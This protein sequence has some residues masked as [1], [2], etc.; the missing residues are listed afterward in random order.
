MNRLHMDILDPVYCRQWNDLLIAGDDYSVFHTANWAR[1][2]NQSYG[3]EPRY[4]GTI[5]SG[6]LT[7]LVPVM[8]INSYLTGRRGV[9]LPFSDFCEPIL[10]KGFGTGEMTKS[11][12]A[13]GSSVGWKFIEFRGDNG[14]E[15]DTPAYRYYYTHTVNLRSGEKFLYDGLRDS[16][17]RNILKSLRKKVTVKHGT[18]R[19]F[20]DEFYRMNCITRKKHG[21]PPQPYLFFEKLQENLLDQGMGTVFLA[22]YQG[23]T[24]AGSV[25]L[26]CGDKVLYKY[27]ASDLEY[28]HLR[29]NN[30]VMWEAIRFYSSAGYGQLSFGRTE[31]DNE[32]LRQFKNGWGGDEQLIRYYRYDIGGERYVSA[33]KSVTKG[34]E[35]LASK[36]PLPLLKIAGKC[37]YRHMG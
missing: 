1:T 32:G 7:T 11:I 3:Y 20:V 14:Q 10:P 24:I 23:A 2:L 26:N 31:P 8:E 22:D 37:L 6:R 21:L 4:F 33:E 28:L 34:Y 36:L 12:A 13:H 30:L 27:G 35:S 16:T 5:E 29:A 9:S 15:A 25:F 18:S 17:R 19:A